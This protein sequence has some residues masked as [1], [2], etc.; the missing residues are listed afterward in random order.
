MMGELTA[1]IAHE[2]NQPL[3][4]IVSN[5][6]ACLRWLAGD[7][8]KLDEIREAIG[9][10]VR[11]GKRAGEVIARIRGMTKRVGPRRDKLDVNE[12]VREVIAIVHDE[13]KTNG[14]IV[15]TH[16]AEDVS[17]VSGD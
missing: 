7:P 15:R 6:S 1:S 13:A 8:P 12:I 9:D 5:G 16:F 2:V 3:S 14:V 17:R 11:D 10:M 4:G